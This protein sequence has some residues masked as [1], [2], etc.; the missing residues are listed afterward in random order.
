MRKRSLHELYLL[1]GL[2][3][4]VIFFV[5]TRDGDV[6]LPASNDEYLL[7]VE[8]EGESSWLD[9]QRQFW[10]QLYRDLE[11][12]RPDTTPLM[13][14]KGIGLSVPFNRSSTRK[15]PERLY[16]TSR[17]KKAVKQSHAAFVA[18]IS[19]RQYPLPYRVGTRG[20]VTTV[21]RRYLNVAIVSIRMLRRTGSTLPVEI[22][23][24]DWSE[25]DLDVCGYIM[26]SLGAACIVL[27]DIFDISMEN[28]VNIKRY[29]F[30][31]MSI[32]FS[33]FE[34]VLFL[35]SDCF[36]VADPEYLFDER[37]FTN[38]G[39]I[40]W[41]DFWFA[42]E[43]PLFF[44]IAEI[45]APDI[46]DNPSSESGEI[47]YSK[48]KHELGLLLAAY[49][50]YYGPEF[51]YPLQAQGAP[52]EGDK[53]T[54]VWAAKAMRG[55]FYTVKAAVH[56]L[57]YYTQNS[58]WRGSA[59]VQFD[60]AKD[61]ALANDLS[62]EPLQ[63]I[64]DPRSRPLFLHVNTPKIDPGQIFIP[65]PYLSFGRTSPTLDSDLRM[66]R[67]WHDSKDG[68]RNFFERDVEAEMWEE[69]KNI[70]CQYERKLSAWADQ[71]YICRNATIYYETVFL[72]VN[73]QDGQE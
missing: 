17:Q 35:D 13:H 27:E 31:V 45:K 41:P 60:P 66:R 39:L 62:N 53:E 73:R 37:P 64:Y 15:R 43:S 19:A 70:A 3:L 67:I 38:T 48:R 29:Q 36:P 54:Y 24:A 20:I 61:F 16:M 56:P 23:L 47:M 59:M 5:F 2:C 25:Y 40:I 21:S 46:R 26:P 58:D 34:D 50:N 52:G 63:E 65:P 18:K 10:R 12:H 32:L 4:L 51:Y 42:S 28:S 68:A 6:D 44:E 49:Y 9:L 30:K 7:T 22:F 72:D 11:T 33:S 55:S 1:A 71:I 8:Y 57:G 14:P 69:V